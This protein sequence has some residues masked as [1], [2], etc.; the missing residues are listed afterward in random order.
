MA[1]SA[2]S[3]QVIIF[4]LSGVMVI[5]LSVM[6]VTVL[7]P[8]VGSPSSYS[9]LPKGVAG[10]WTAMRQAVVMMLTLLMAYLPLGTSH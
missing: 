7:H 10:L 5:M 2:P 6:G 3:L 4:A 1:Y 8:A 9:A